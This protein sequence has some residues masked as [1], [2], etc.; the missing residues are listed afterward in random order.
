MEWRSTIICVLYFWLKTKYV[1]CR[2]EVLR[3]RTTPGIAKVIGMLFCIAGVGNLAFVKGPLFKISWHCFHP[4][5]HLDIQQHH[6]VGSTTS[7]WIKGSFLMLLSNTLWGLWLVLQV[8]FLF[9]IFC[10]FRCELWVY[11]QV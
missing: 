9:H 6:H 7:T 1:L 11:V 5:G 10:F 4:F 8:A 3:L 2:M